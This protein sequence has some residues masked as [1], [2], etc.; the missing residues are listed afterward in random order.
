L[1]AITFFKV[2]ID[3][4][5]GHFKLSQNKAQQ[6]KRKIAEKLVVSG[7]AKLAAQ[8]QENSLI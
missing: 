3:T 2:S 1:T 5:E 6:V 7:K 4:F 8:I